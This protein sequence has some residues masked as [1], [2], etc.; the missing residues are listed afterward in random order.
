MIK[1]TTCDQNA[2]QCYGPGRSHCSACAAGLLLLPKLSQCVPAGDDDEDDGID[3]G[4]GGDDGDGHGAT[5]APP[6][7]AAGLLI[8]IM[9]I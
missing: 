6:P 4:D 1:T 9:A 5:W 2:T 7:S 3:N 8:L